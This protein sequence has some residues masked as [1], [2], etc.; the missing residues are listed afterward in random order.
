MPPTD[1]D[2]TTAQT[3]VRKNGSECDRSIGTK[4]RGVE[5]LL[6]MH[7]STR[8]MADIVPIIHRHLGLKGLKKRLLKILILHVVM[9]RSASTQCDLSRELV[10]I[11]VATGAIEN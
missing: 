7:C 5:D 8:Q 1:G 3:K 2:G 10:A 4:S 9:Q 11:S 6:Q